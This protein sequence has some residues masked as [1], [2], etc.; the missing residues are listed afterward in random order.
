MATTKQKI[1]ISKTYE[2]LGKGNTKNIG[3]IM[4][5]SGYSK[6]VAKNPQNLTQS[7]AWQEAKAEIDYA[8]HIKELDKM[9]STKN[10][11]DKYNVLRSK[12]MLF[13]LGDLYPA[14][15]S[16]VLGLFGAL[17]DLE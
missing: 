5:E 6:S 10:N 3:E 12:D 8:R 1:A 2:N 11:T 15:K 16:K 7:K 13:K 9:A 14:Q 17:E 4:L